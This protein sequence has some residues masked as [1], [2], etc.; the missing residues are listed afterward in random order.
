M[1]IR[2]ITVID[3]HTD[4]V[5]EV[6]RGA[7]IPDMMRIRDQYQGLEHDGRFSVEQTEL[8]FNALNEPVQCDWC[9]NVGKIYVPSMGEQDCPEC[10]V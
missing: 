10:T 4:E 7:R 9:G 1:N 8:R 2:I 5:I 3:T 6:V